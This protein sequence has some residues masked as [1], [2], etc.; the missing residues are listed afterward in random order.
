MAVV[1]LLLAFA[2]TLF[3]RPVLTHAPAPDEAVLSLGTLELHTAVLFDVAI[4]CLV[5]G[6]VVG[7][8]DHIGGAAEDE[9]E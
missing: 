6:F 8:L 2:P 5:F 3:G 4:F 7:V 9:P 1:G